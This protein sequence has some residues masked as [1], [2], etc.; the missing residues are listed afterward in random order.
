MK[1][2]ITQQNPPSKKDILTL[3]TS[4][5]KMK[6]QTAYKACQCVF[7]IV[8]YKGEQN[9]SKAWIYS[10]SKNSMMSQGTTL[11]NV[12]IAFVKLLGPVRQRLNKEFLEAPMR[13][14]TCSPAG[15]LA[16]YTGRRWLGRTYFT[17]TRCWNATLNHFD[18]W[19]QCLH[20]SGCSCCTTEINKSY[21][22]YNG[23]T[24]L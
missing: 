5:N 4:W 2:L 15:T 20:R 21:R 22:G 18:Q 13:G 16:C 12:S 3:Y 14:L 9:P 11:L 23:V 17:L 24:S 10:M 7:K 6:I 19:G 8:K 1:T